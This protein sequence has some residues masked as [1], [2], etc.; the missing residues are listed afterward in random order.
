MSMRTFVFASPAG[1]ELYTDAYLPEASGP[2]PVVIAMHGGGW[3]AGTRETYKYI[4]PLLAE[5]GYALLSIDYRLVLKEQNRYPA[6]SDDVRAAI[7]YV[8]EHAAELNVDPSRIVLMGDSAGGHLAALV[9]LTERPQVKAVVGI[10][11]VYDLAAQWQYD[12]PIRL[13]EN[14]SRDFLGVSLPENRQLY[15]EASPISHAIVANRGPSF[16]LAWGTNDDIVDPA[17]SEAFMSALKQAGFWA[18]P[19]IQFAPHFWIGDPLDE[20]GSHSAYFAARL[21][22]FLDDRVKGI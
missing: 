2:A 20:P 15:F 16:L 12:L 13:G 21:L 3:R 17:Q 7:R 19:V 5:R 10:F 11:G 6:A 8:R 18:R 14:I 4:G 1:R 9:G 22:R